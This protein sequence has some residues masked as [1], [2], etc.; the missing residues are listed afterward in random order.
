[1]GGTISKFN[2]SGAFQ[3]S[4]T[5]AGSGLATDSAGN[6][7]A[8]NYFGS[9]IT[10]FDTSGSAVLT[11]NSNLNG[12][13]GLAVSPSAK[14]YAV[15]QAGSTISVF[16]LTGGLDSTISGN[17]LAPNAIAFDSTGNFYV[18]NG[19]G[20]TISKFNSAGVFQ[21]G[22]ATTAAPLFVAVKPTVVPEPST[23][24]LGTLSVSALMF[25]RSRR[26]KNI[27]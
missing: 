2:S 4:I 11:I 5:S 22:W 6:L 1:V 13:T 12:P 14:L 3:S 19:V 8:S 10:K 7:F 9:S 25:V 23:W 24:V 16:G 26:N 17:T 18:T 20:S 15:N 27:V 21:F